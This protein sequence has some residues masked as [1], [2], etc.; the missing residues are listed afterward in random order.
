MPSADQVPVKSP[1][2]RMQW[3]LWVVLIAGST[4][5]ALRAVRP[6]NLHIT[7]DVGA[8]SS[9]RKRD[10]F[11]VALTFGHRGPSHPRKLV[12]KRDR[13][14]LGWPPGQQ[15]R[16]PTPVFGAMD[17]GIADHRK[18]TRCEQASQIAVALFADTAKLVLAPLECCLG[19][20]PIQ[21]EK[22]RPDRNALGLATLATKAVANAGLTPGNYRAACWSRSTG[23]KR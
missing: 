11:L 7:P 9:S 15:R 14:N 13:G 17:L 19:T 21:A 6:P 1:H 20:S 23:A 22:S 8:I 16:K 2:S 10:G 18:C 12:G 3:H 4:G 5:S